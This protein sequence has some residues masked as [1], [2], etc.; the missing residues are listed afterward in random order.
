MAPTAG[1]PRHRRLQLCSRSFAARA[2]A[3]TACLR[4]FLRPYRPPRQPPA[5]ECSPVPGLHPAWKCSPVPGLHPAWDSPRSPAPES[6]PAPAHP[7]GKPSPYLGPLQS[8]PPTLLASPSTDVGC[9][10][11]HP[12]SRLEAGR[13]PWNSPRPARMHDRPPA[14]CRARRDPRRP[15]GSPR[16]QCRARGAAPGRCCSSSDVRCTVSGGA[17]QRATH[18]QT[19]IRFKSFHSYACS[20]RGVPGTTVP[21]NIPPKARCPIGTSRHVSPGCW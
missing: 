3:L 20:P 10:S 9:R 13:R 6:C 8:A 16:Q 17:P 5:W 12:P 21:T 2:L 1:S 14:R 7:M 15:W 11:G 4:Q 19:P 18:Q